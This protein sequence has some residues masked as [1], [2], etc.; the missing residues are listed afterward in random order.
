MGE[1][2]L[3]GFNDPIL[4]LKFYI[5]RI[6]GIPGL[7]FTR[8]KKIHKTLDLPTET[9]DSQR[10][11]YILIVDVNAS[12]CRKFSSYDFDPDGST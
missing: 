7:K 4:T 9:R 2:D 11:R 10:P 5:L 6:S 8:K 12:L 1:R 3:I